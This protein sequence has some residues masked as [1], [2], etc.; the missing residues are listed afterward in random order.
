MN[1]LEFIQQKTSESLES[2]K[3]L[4]AE[5]AQVDSTCSQTEAQIRIYGDQLDRLN[6]AEAESK[7]ALQEMARNIGQAT[8]DLENLEIKKREIEKSLE[9]YIL[10]SDRLNLIFHE[11]VAKN[12]EE[13][14][15]LHQQISAAER[16][17]A[18]AQESVSS[19]QKKA[20]KEQ[21]KLNN[22][23]HKVLETYNDKQ[24]KQLKNLYIH[25][26]QRAI[27]LCELKELQKSRQASPEILKLCES[28][29]ELQKLHDETSLSDVKSILRT[30]LKA[31][32][33]QLA[34]KLPQAL[35]YLDT[36]PEAV[37]TLELLYYFEVTG[38][39][40]VILPIEPSDW[41]GSEVG[42]SSSLM[43]EAMHLV[44]QMINGLG[45][46]SKD[47]DFTTIENLPVFKSNFDREDI[48]ILQ[49]FNFS[50]GGSDITRFIL[51]AIP[52]E[53]QKVM[54]HEN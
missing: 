14:A 46:K 18:Q 47:G 27:A 16:T 1:I 20:A 5:I 31:I 52:P 42:E 13:K 30:S 45:L 43:S 9:C 26:K 10:E 53:L 17:I 28:H 15:T 19:L 50:S 54:R 40:I 21:T 24:A 35:K 37:Q 2:I 4:Q 38:K 12:G 29:A 44:W 7:K 51:T 3:R 39:S 32:E 23:M 34:Q 49:G 8:L 22:V 41:I 33:S 25:H 11:T 6:L 36:F 48:S